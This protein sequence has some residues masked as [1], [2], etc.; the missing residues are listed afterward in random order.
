MNGSENSVW[1]QNLAE[2]VGRVGCVKVL[3]ANLKYR[4][5]SCFEKLNLPKTV[6]R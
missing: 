5:Q 6:T 4:G 2:K 3:P 1:F